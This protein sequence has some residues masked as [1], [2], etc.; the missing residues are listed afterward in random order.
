MKKVTFDVYDW[1]D[2]T[3]LM[4]MKSLKVIL[5]N[6]ATYFQALWD[7]KQIMKFSKEIKHIRM[8]LRQIEGDFRFTLY[9]YPIVTKMILWQETETNWIV[10]VNM[11]CTYNRIFALWHPHLADNITLPF[12]GL[13][14]LGTV[15]PTHY[16]YKNL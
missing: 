13:R 10:V 3:E 5:K 14:I 16:S 4:S 9:K 2:F 15:N 8:N 6:W 7:E 1:L 11:N 12:T